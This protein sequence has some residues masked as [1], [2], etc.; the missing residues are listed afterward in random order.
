LLG[1]KGKTV[2]VTLA[3]QNRE[4]T[5]MGARREAGRGHGKRRK[6]KRVRTKFQ[7]KI[8]F[9]PPTP[10]GEVKGGEKKEEFETPRREGTACRISYG[11]NEIV[12]E[13]G[14]EQ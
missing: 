13:V 7:K 1:K 8:T 12:R 14:G 3:K 4:N 5:R 9:T 11:D 10:V 6:K 2:K